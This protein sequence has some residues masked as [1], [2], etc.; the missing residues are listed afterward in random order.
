[1]FRK[2]II[3][4]AFFAIQKFLISKITYAPLKAYLDS[5]INPASEI[6]DILT[7]ANPANGDQLK[8]FWE[9]NHKDLI[10]QD[11]DLAKKIVSDKVTNVDLRDTILRLLNAITE[12]D[13]ITSRE[14]GNV[15]N[16]LPA[17]IIE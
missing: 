4:T 16:E 11:I 1:M 3:S 6:A 9:A 15:E 2:L 17:N 10:V 14:I 13:L 8:A 12:G 7:D 5:L